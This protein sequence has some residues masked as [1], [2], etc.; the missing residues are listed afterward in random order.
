MKQSKILFTLFVTL[1]LIGGTFL[2]A[3]CN[4]RSG[5]KQKAMPTVS[6]QVFNVNSLYYAIKKTLPGRVIASRIAEIRP[7]VNG[8]ILKREFTESSDIKA[9]E[10]LYQIDP[11]V[12]QATY[13]SAMANLSSQKAK[14]N[15]VELTLKR[16]HGLLTS[17]AISQQEYDVA[18]ANVKQARA[19]VMIAEANVN[20]AKVNLDYTKVYSPIDGYIGKSSVTE[21]ALVAAGQANPLAVVQQL[22]PIYVDMTQAVINYEQN[23]ENRGALF[24]Q[25]SNVPVEVFFSDGTK[26]DEIGY[27]KFSDKTVDETTGTVKLRAEFPN[28]LI[29]QRDGSQQRRLLPG[30]FVK[31]IITLGEMDHAILVPQSGITSDAQGHYTAKVVNENGL[32]E[33]RSNIQVYGGI[34]NYWIVTS[35]IHAGDQVVTTGLMNLSSMPPGA[36]VKAK[37]IGTTSLSQEELDQMV[38][39]NIN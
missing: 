23:T 8:I 38:A 19:Q 35:G 20:S 3:N 32:I 34:R 7:Q 36:S 22:D 1:T 16:Y 2:L 25:P 30:M 28:P 5:S 24:Q 13:D 17:K 9:G 14:S 11:A 4:G 15:I 18:C 31:P 37:I 26:F 12:Y 29:I 10:S 21:G 27:V 39:K 6:V 33:Q